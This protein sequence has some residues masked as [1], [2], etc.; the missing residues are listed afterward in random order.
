M[1]K[2]CENHTDD[3]PMTIFVLQL[4]LTQLFRKSRSLEVFHFKQDRDP[5]VEL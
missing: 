5:V 4:I 1:L 3:I 2:K